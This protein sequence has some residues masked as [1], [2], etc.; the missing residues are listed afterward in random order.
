MHRSRPVRANRTSLPHII[1]PPRAATGP[2][3]PTSDVAVA[4]VAPHTTISMFDPQL[5]PLDP[6]TYVVAP[7]LTVST[8]VSLGIALLTAVPRPAP[9]PIRL[10]ATRLR[11]TVIE[12]Q[13]AWGRQLDVAEASRAASPRQADNR[14]DRSLRATS[15]RIEAF[16]LLGPEATPEHETAVAIKE[17]L[18]PDGLRFLTL[19]WE[20]QW[21]HIERLVKLLDADEALAVDLE[22]LVGPSILAELRAAHEAYGESLG[23]TVSRPSTPTVSLVEPIAALRAA[24]ARYALQ[25]VAMQDHDRS[26]V[27]IARRALAPLDELRARQARRRGVGNGRSS[28]EPS[29]VDPELEEDPSVSP[30]TPVPTIEDEPA[31]A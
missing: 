5:H 24:I 25:V 12:L 16:I 28:A 13:D 15:M 1:V 21:A 11:G 9:K 2:K 17:R 7:R 18:F 4:I 26:R 19:P 22:A 3:R 8:G 14:S 6:S 10:A 27:E 30:R 31:V 23:I 29:A 20:Q